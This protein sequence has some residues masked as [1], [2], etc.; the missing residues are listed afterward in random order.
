MLNIGTKNIDTIYF[1][2]LVTNF[3]ET[4]RYPISYK[5]IWKLLP[6]GNVI[7]YMHINYII[8]ILYNKTNFMSNISFILK[9]YNGLNE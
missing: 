4:L 8:D 7:I 2:V 1:T 6:A 5:F 9:I 3:H